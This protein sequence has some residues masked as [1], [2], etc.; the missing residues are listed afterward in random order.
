[1][2]SERSKPRGPRGPELRI[3]D[4]AKSVGVG[5]ETVRYYQRRGLL[6]APP[7]IRNGRRVYDG[8]AVLELRFIRR[9]AGL[10]FTLRDIGLLLVTRGSGR[11]SCDVV[12]DKLEALGTRLTE[13]VRKL[14][15]RRKAIERL[16]LACRGDRRARECKALLE[17]GEIDAFGDG[18]PPRD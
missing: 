9:C 8:E 18:E 10:G 3:G 1:V 12:H 15:L 5:V 14:A 13:E 11:Q 7:R 6:K 2:T 17:L 4:L 16:L